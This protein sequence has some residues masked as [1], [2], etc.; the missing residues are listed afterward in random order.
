VATIQSV[1]IARFKGKLYENHDKVL[2]QT[3]KWK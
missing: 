2:T 3:P 1:L